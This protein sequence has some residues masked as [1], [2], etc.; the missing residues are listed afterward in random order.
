MGNPKDG[1]VTVPYITRYIYEDA[2]NKTV[3][4]NPRGVDINDPVDGRTEEFRDGL[5]RVHKVIIDEGGLNLTTVF[6]YDGN[7]NQVTVKDP[8]GGKTDAVSTYDGLNRIIH[9]QYRLSYTEAFVYDNNNNLTEYTDKRGTLFKNVYD[10]LNRITEKKVSESITPGGGLLT[11]MASAYN[12][13]ANK[14]T[15]TDAN[16]NQ[17][18]MEFD[19]LQRVTLLTDPFG[20]TVQNIYDG[21]NKR[22]V[23]D[24]KGHK[25][26][27]RY[28]GVNRLRFMDEYGT[29]NSRITGTETIYDDAKN[30][31]REIDRR[32]IEQIRQNDSRGRTITLSREHTDLA[33][34]YE[35]MVRVDLETYEYDGNNNVTLF[36]DAVE[37]QV[38]NVYD[39]A[40]RL[41]TKME[42]FGA[43]A[44]VE[45]DMVYTY[46][47]VNNIL[48]VRDGRTP[49]GSFDFEYTYDDRYRK[50]TEKN[51]KGETTTYTYDGNNNL[52]TVTEPKGASGVSVTNGILQ[53]TD[54]IGQEFTTR[55]EYDELDTLIAIDESLRNING[56]TPAGITRFI[57]DANRN[58]I[59]QQDASGNLVTYKYDE[60]NRLTET[61]QHTILG[62]FDGNS[63]RTEAVTLGNQS[64]ALLWQYGYDA[65]SNQDFIID[66]NGQIVGG[67]I[68]GAAPVS[69]RM[70]YDYLDRLVAKAYSNHVETNLDFQMVAITYTYDGNSNLLTTTETKTLGAGTVAEQTI[71]TYDPLDRIQTKLHKDYDDPVGKLID[72]DYDNQGNRKTV[73]DADGNLAVYTY[74]ERNRLKTVDTEASPPSTIYEWWEDSLLKK[75]TYANGSIC[76]RSGTD[77][78]DKAD[79]LL[80]TINHPNNLAP[81]FSVYEYTYDK[82]SNRLTQTEIQAT[83]PVAAPNT[84]ETTTYIYDNLNR[85]KTVTYGISGDI[86][87]TYQSNGN[88]LTESGNDPITGQMVNRSFVYDALVDK[89]GV[90]YSGVNSSEPHH[91][92]DQF[93]SNGDL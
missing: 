15:E 3:T 79:R 59:A 51:G 35:N 14:V 33:M 67:P 12:D 45:A 18:V 72:Y 41:I 5:H 70:E 4:V 27:F 24:K 76:D 22:R 47:D 44:P 69:E 80:K 87:Y 88:R 82:N 48:S 60:L 43:G 91:R 36:A 63:T 62:T 31:V 49:V 42:G 53:F 74:D 52:E 9:T 1:A 81:P 20:K 65:N 11:L 13:P 55:Y 57:Y 64:P 92:Q 54:N 17:N 2:Q 68:A 66:P 73:T 23:I 71:C 29:G 93:R 58:K 39:G 83:L 61:R 34:H 78:Y 90:T 6:T 38:K 40:D 26:E 77:A 19:E 37:N 8:E 56:D 86:T 21:V 10:D 25:T 32:G 85:L 28:D 84:T 89:P 16:G 7:G 50:V 46:D 30:R 75:V